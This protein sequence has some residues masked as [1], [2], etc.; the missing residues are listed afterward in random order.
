MAVLEYLEQEKTHYRVTEHEPVYTA[1]QLA[2][3]EKVKPEQVAKAVVVQADGKYFICVLSADRL[4]DFDALCQCLRV[5]N[6]K[7]ANESE[8]VRLFGDCEVGAEPPL[9][10][11][12][13]LPVVMDENLARDKQIVF[14]AG[15]HS[16]SVWMDMDEYLGLVKP[17]I[18]NFTFQSQGPGAIWPEMYSSWWMDPFA[19]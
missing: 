12:Y 10:S 11:H 1:M 3:V 9:G 17:Q 15:E 13:D 14:F 6:V 18:R 16:R 19:F 2:R 7:L 8:M 5:K 4:I